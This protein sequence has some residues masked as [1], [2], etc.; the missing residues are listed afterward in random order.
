ML[1]TISESLFL[2]LFNLLVLLSQIWLYSQE[3]MA[4]GHSALIVLN[5]HNLKNERPPS[6]GSLLNPHVK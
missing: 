1:A 3:I 6:H 4:F 5:Y 2:S